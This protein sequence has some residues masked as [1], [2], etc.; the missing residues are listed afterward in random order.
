MN[1]QTTPVYVYV[2]ALDQDEPKH[3]KEEKTEIDDKQGDEQEE[4]K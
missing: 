4:K 3:E 1:K 2:S